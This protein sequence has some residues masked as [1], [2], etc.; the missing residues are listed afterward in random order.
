MWVSSWQLG[1]YLHRTTVYDNLYF[2][3]SIVGKEIRCSFSCHFDMVKNIFHAR[4]GIKLPVPHFISI[5]LV[6]HGSSCT[7]AS[8][9][10]FYSAEM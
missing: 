2:L 8:H 5:R 7:V 6:F 4:I 10:R 9:R 3:C 1:G